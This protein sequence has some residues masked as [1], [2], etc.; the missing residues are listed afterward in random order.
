VRERR[1]IIGRHDKIQLRASGGLR[2][3]ANDADELC[4]PRDVGDPARIDI[5]R[6]CRGRA[7]RVIDVNAVLIGR[8]GLGRA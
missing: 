7:R 6:R 4:L 5:R 2:T 3:G 1:G 8:A